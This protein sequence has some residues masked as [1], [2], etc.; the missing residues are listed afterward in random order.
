MSRKSKPAETDTPTKAALVAEGRAPERDADAVAAAEAALVAL[1]ESG[2]IT[3]EE[4]ETADAPDV[5]APLSPA[6]AAP[7]A[8]TEPDAAPP[9]PIND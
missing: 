9:P 4:P 3:R 8:P 6:E 5:A 7:P 2:G 1:A